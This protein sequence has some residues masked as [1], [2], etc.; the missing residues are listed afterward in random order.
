MCQSARWIIC[1][2][3]VV[4]L[5]SSAALAVENITRKRDKPIS[6][7]VT[8]VSKTEVTV[9]VKNPKEETIKV[10]A[11]E[12]QSISW[13]GDPPEANVARSDDAGG[14][15]QRAIDGYQKS[16][17]ASKATNSLA[18]VELEYGV[19]RATARLALTDPSRIDDAIKKLEEFRSKRADHYRFYEAVELLGQLYLA[20]KD[21][22][23]AQVA[24]DTLAK[25]PWKESQLAAKIAIGRLLQADNK[26]D[27]ALAAF[28]AV[29]EQSADGRTEESQRQEAMLGKSQVLISQ[30]K[31][32]EAQ[33]LLD[34]VI[35]KADPAESK[36]MAEAYVRLGD[37]LREQGKDKD[38]V[39]AY[40]HV[41]VLFA[42]EKP[43]QAEAL[44]HLTRLLEKTGQ[45]AKAAELRDKLESDEF[46]N[47]EWARQLKSS[48]AG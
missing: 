16:L 40:L 41:E 2:L 36:V 12:V 48:S 8:D 43:L 35:D 37:C 30:K 15:Y 10:P 4:C 7:D 9:K 42:S 5:S 19:T 11:N 27:A 44:F 34:Q 13:T 32:D 22:V 26:A 38:A 25:A 46:K 21:F 18:K 23:K 20:K 28:D 33:N 29:I 31:Y 1:A 45:K 14:R 3:V 6:G 24:F 39:F 47:T 17:Q